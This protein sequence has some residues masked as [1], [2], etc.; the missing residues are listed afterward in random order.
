M[1]AISFYF[2]W[3]DR[4]IRLNGGPRKVGMAS[5]KCSKSSGLAEVVVNDKKL[6]VGSIPSKYSVGD[7]ILVRYIPVEYCVV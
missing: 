5:V 1:F 6:H 2:S 7:L 4:Y 3:T